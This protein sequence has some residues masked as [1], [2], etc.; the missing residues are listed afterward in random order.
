MIA[1]ALRS[2]R[3]G[4][5][6]MGQPEHWCRLARVARLAVIAAGC[7]TLA[8]CGSPFSLDPKLGVSSSPRVVDVG[9]PVPKG[10]GT[11][12]LGKPYTVAGVTYVPQ[13]DPN[14]RAEGLASFY[15]PEFHG[16]LTAN[17]E[18]FDM[19]S[20]SAAHPTL[21]IPSYV[22]VTNLRNHKSV[23]VRINDRG[24]YAAN[25]VIDVSRKT[26]HVLGFHDNGLAR[27][28][29][30]YVGPASLDGADDRLLLATLREGE[31]APAPSRVML[32]SLNTVLPPE[33]RAANV[34]L[35]VGRPFNLG[36]PQQVA[37]AD[38][39]AAPVPTPKSKVKLQTAHYQPS[40]QPKSLQEQ[41]RELGA[42]G[43]MAA[44]TPAS[45]QTT[46]L[47]QRALY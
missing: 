16:R 43:S 37:A 25:R 13:E 15:G 24:P 27:V 17:G 29:V 31:P 11:Y 14:Y 1:A 5:G 39:Q 44:Y 28:R 12:R 40:E 4:Q 26:A 20:L 19:E 33:R 47:N 2:Q 8:H 38:V 7:L 30:E 46:D 3:A 6:I 32:A 45:T 18:V 36:E 23:I 41:A 42:P 21:P 10:G 9:D 34:P 35:P 22:R